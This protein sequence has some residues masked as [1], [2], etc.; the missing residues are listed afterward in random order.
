MDGTRRRPYHPSLIGMTY[1]KRFPTHALCIAS[2]LVAA[3][4]GDDNAAPPGTGGSA[5]SA[6]S[7]GSGGTSGGAST[8]DS[9]IDVSVAAD[10]S[11]DA[12]SE[13]SDAGK[14]N[15]PSL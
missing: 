14:L 11:S 10:S 12:A 9:S 5:G 2:L 15:C 6:G 3:C 13:V 7:A 4:S 8:I 1:L